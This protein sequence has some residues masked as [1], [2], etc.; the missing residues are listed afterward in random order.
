MRDF[1]TGYIPLVFWISGTVYL[2]YEI[3]EFSE[4]A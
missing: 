3:E 4:M 1:E 2:F